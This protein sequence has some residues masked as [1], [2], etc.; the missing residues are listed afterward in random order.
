MAAIPT[1][2]PLYLVSGSADPV[3]GASGSVDTLFGMYKKLG[4]ADVE[5]KL[6]PEARHEILNET[7]RD[8]VT[9]DIMAWLAKHQPRIIARASGASVSRPS[10]YPWP[11]FVPG[12]PSSKALPVLPGLGSLGPSTSS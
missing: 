1:S 5:M 3:G 8:E 4:I 9:S 10:I 6:Y 11:F 2:L 7:N 12:G